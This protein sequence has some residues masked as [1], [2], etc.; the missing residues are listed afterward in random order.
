MKRR[1]GEGA[2]RSLNA[3]KIHVDGKRGEYGV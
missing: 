1:R 2:K 3:E